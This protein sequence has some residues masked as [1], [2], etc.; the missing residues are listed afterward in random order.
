MTHTKAITTEAPNRRIPVFVVT[1]EN[2]NASAASS[3]LKRPADE[4][5]LPAITGGW[6][7]WTKG[8]RRNDT[9]T[10]QHAQDC[11]IRET[12]ETCCL[13]S[14]SRRIA[15]GNHPAWWFA[16]GGIRDAFQTIVFGWKRWNCSRS[17]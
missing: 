14:L 4:F 8:G 13:R 16:E 9:T 10:R 6:L 15:A 5:P 12:A 2:P 11:A 1:G 7:W 17:R 3:L